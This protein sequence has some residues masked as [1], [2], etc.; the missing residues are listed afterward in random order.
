MYIL[1]ALYILTWLISPISAIPTTS[2]RLKTNPG[3][4][5]HRLTPRT[6]PLVIPN[7]DL[8]LRTSKTNL[9]IGPSYFAASALVNL[10]TSVLADTVHDYVNRAPVNNLFLNKG[11]FVLIFVADSSE[12]TIP[13]DV[14]GEFCGQM[15]EWTQMGYLGTY[16]RGYWNL[17]NTLGVYVSLRFQEETLM[18]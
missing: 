10:Y 13:W 5:A 12:K 14:V 17:A 11:P 8:I 4:I 15:I 9:V 16:E 1:P 18:P 6:H 2:L 7:S 3:P